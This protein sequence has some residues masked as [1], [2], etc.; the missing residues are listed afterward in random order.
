MDNLEKV[1]K[2]RERANVSYEEARAALEAS[3][4]DLLDAMVSLEKQGKTAAPEKAD[5]S[6]SYEQQDNYLK[7]RETVDEQRREQTKVGRTLRD[8]I[9]H[10]F[11]VCVDNSFCVRR[12]D[13]EIFRI[14]LIALVIILL[15]AWKVVIP[16][17]IVALFFGC[18]YSFDG[19]DDLKKAN[20]FMESAGNAADSMKEGFYAKDRKDENT[21]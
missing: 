14:P 3:N 11:R 2:L 1:E 5:F 17:A 20:E 10:F 4:W 19:R 8:S 18:R 16:V 9:R 21:K 15:I 6:T 12:N 13:S 7:V